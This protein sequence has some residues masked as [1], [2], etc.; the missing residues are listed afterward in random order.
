MEKLVAVLLLSLLANAADAQKY[1]NASTPVGSLMGT[2]KDNVATFLA[3]PYAH[4]PIIKRR[5]EMPEWPFKWEG[6]RNASKHAFACIQGQIGETLAPIFGNLQ[7]SE[8]CL[9]LDIYVDGG[10]I[11]PKAKMPVVV[12]I[13]GGG[14]TAGSSALYDFSQFVKGRG[15]VAVAIQ[16][17]L[18]LFGFAKSPDDEKI[19]GNLGLHDQVA[20]IKWVKKYIGSFGG[21]PDS[22]T[23]QGES[24][25]SISIA[26][27]MLSPLMN[28]TFQRAIM[29]SG[30]TQTINLMHEEMLLL[31]MKELI[32]FVHCK[33]EEAQDNDSYKCLKYVNAIHMKRFVEK[34]RSKGI[35]FIP[36]RD[37]SYFGGKDPVDLERQGKFV[38]KV[39]S[40]L[41]GHNG[42]EGAM[43]LSFIAPSMFP[44]Q[45]Q[46]FLS[47]LWKWQLKAA[48]PTMPKPFREVMKYAIDR[49]YTNKW[50]L[51]S[52]EAANKIGKLLGDTFFTCPNIQT[53]RAILK[54]N[55]E[56]K[57]YYYH[58]LVR[59]V[60]NPKNI[61]PYIQDALHGEELQFVLGRPFVDLPSFTGSEMQFSKSMMD[62]WAEFVKTGK[63]INKKWLPVRVSG[64]LIIPK[65]LVYSNT[66][67][68]EFKPNF[69]K[70]IC[71]SLSKELIGLPT[72]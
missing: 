14:F 35:S 7:E 27:H 59:P 11:D 31:S 38:N 26:Y 56:T 22:I 46:P 29:E 49:A 51:S 28:G 19:P 47:R 3:V 10:K 41:I 5:F 24:A 62:E 72:S 68:T 23:L 30:A 1:I 17:R 66:T 34:A 55:P 42:N 20:A 50:V 43:F 64:R 32:E 52:T 70:N 8:D 18:G 15:V 67:G 16:Y 44:A 21:N 25:G 58:F 53:T 37:S 6:T 9:Y 36:S 13:H 4:P 33:P 63:V 45:K 61:W 48:V 60:L 69:P 54:W 57:L 40:V 2:V 39:D 65:H 12:F 71:I